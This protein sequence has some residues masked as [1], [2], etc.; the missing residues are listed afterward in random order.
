MSHNE[1]D[2]MAL[3][4]GIGAVIAVHAHCGDGWMPGPECA[5]YLRSA[6][7]DVGGPEYLVV[8]VA[9]VAIGLA[10]V[11]AEDAGLSLDHVLQ[12]VGLVVARQAGG[13][14]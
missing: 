11:V 14:A 8:Q 6:A 5:A 7:T 10:K 4:S 9:L 12:T 1:F 3:A 13:A 2:A